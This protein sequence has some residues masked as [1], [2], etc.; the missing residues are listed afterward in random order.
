MLPWHS[1]TR[2]RARFHSSSR[3]LSRAPV[4]TTFIRVYVNSGR[5]AHVL[6]LSLPTNLFHSLSLSSSFSEAS[7]LPLSLTLALTLALARP[8]R[9]SQIEPGDFQKLAA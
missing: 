5:G 1:H 9:G 4:Y 2:I 8:G 6:L 3:G 7:P